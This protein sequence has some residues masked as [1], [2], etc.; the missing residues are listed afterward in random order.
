MGSFSVPMAI[1]VA[2]HFNTTM[3]L[4]D[5]AGYIAQPQPITFHVVPVAGGHA[6]KLIED[7]VEVLGRNTDTLVADGQLVFRA[8]N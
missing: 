5:H 2:F 8:I 7:A 4:A 1:G 3:M 6:E